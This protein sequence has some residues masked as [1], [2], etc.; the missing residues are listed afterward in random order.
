MPVFAGPIGRTRRDRPFA[1]A[2]LLLLGSI[3]GNR[4]RILMEPWCREG[5]D[6]QGVERDRAKHGVEIRGKQRIEE[7]P[8]PVIMERFSREAGLEQG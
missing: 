7:L 6:L 5:I 1:R 4:R 3:Q 8:Q 2:G